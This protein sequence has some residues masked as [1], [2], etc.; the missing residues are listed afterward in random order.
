MSSCGDSNAPS[1]SGG[2]TRCFCFFSRKSDNDMCLLSKG[3][4]MYKLITF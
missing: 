4:I 1:S 3:N 2:N